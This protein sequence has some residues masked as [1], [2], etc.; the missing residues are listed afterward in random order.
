MIDQRRLVTQSYLDVFVV[1]GRIFPDFLAEAMGAVATVPRPLAG[2]L[3][4]LAASGGMPVEVG[5]GVIFGIFS[6]PKGQLENKGGA[7]HDDVM[8]AGACIGMAGKG[9]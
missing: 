1:P 7:E 5:F 9:A 8:T 3:V 4:W 6:A 2:E